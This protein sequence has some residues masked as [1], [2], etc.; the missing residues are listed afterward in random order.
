MQSKSQRLSADDKS[1]DEIHDE[2][3]RRLVYEN[4]SEFVP[5][6]G[7]N[8]LNLQSPDQAVIMYH[9]CGSD[10]R[11]R[12]VDP[13]FCLL[14]SFRD[15]KEASQFAGEHYANSQFSIYVSPSH[16]LWPIRN[17]QDD[18]MCQEANVKLIDELCALHESNIHERKM[19]HD[20]NVESQ[21]TGDS[22]RSLPT[23]IREG[24]D[25]R[26]KNP[27]IQQ[28]LDQISS[29]ET[30]QAWR[31]THD[32]IILGQT[33]AVIFILDDIREETLK[34]EQLEEP[35]VAFLYAAEDVKSCSDYAMYTASKVYKHCDLRVVAMYSWLFPTRITEDDIS[36]IKVAN[37]KIQDIINNQRFTKQKLKEF[38]QFY[39]ESQIYRDLPSPDLS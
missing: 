32:K 25:L 1:L 14:G 39:D 7:F 30:K 29:L 12:H 24:R 23:R 19:D 16:C 22:M 4:N 28:T 35:L 31:Q 36:E 6:P 17:S 3:V 26:S 5:P 38:E 15:A 21:K 8:P 18:Q 11:P 34:G 37:E 2:K 27:E 13:G 20:K 10:Q 33:Y 9:V